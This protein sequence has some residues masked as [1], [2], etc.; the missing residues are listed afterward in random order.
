MSRD[1]LVYNK[2]M[3]EVRGK[4]ASADEVTIGPKLNSCKYLRAV[5]DECLRMSPPVGAA[6]FRET[7]KGGAMV[8]GNYIPE[9]M[10]LGTS[11]YSTHHSKEYFEEPLRF[12]PERWLDNP[13]PDVPAVSELGHT[14]YTPF[15]MG[16]RNCIGKSL[17]VTEATVAMAIV[18]LRFEF[19]GAD[20]NTS[21]RGGGRVGAVKGRDRPEEFQLEDHI[22]SAKKGPLVQ[23]RCR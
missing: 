23:F 8:E 9:G 20:I 5:I 6:P 12:N 1:S 10:L 13:T 16:P 3:T 15:S 7:Q 2:V 11:I 17:A 4:F 22:T 18:C 14:M 19:K 21:N